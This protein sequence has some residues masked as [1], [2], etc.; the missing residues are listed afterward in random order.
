[1]RVGDVHP[2]YSGLSAG[3]LAKAEMSTPHWTETRRGL[4]RL[5]CQILRRSSVGSL[6]KGCYI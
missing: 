6:E 4:G 5:N 3:G 2:V 1:M